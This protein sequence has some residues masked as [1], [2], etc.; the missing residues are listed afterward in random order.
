MLCLYVV[1]VIETE[2]KRFLMLNLS[3]LWHLTV[4]ASHRG[5]FE[6]AAQ[7]T[8]MIVVNFVL[9]L[10]AGTAIWLASATL[11][12][13]G[14]RSDSKTKSTKFEVQEMFQILDCI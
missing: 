6:L 9:A 10:L 11:F 8:A 2:S 5:K 14:P 12:K 13:R 4:W 3:A 7:N 1:F